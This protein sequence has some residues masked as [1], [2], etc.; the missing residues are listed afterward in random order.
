MNL[1]RVAGQALGITPRDIQRASVY[2][3][4][5]GTYVLGQSNNVGEIQDIYNVELGPDPM[6]S[7]YGPISAPGE[8]G[9]GRPGYA[10]VNGDPMNLHQRYINGVYGNLGQLEEEALTERLTESGKKYGYKHR[11]SS[12]FDPKVRNQWR[13]ENGMPPATAWEDFRAHLG[14]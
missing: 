3:D 4:L 12:E 8:Y 14:I 11:F 1:R 6:R 9:S 2:Q 13:A 10:I 5:D 7:Q